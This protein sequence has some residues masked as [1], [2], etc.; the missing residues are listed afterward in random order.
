MSRL[1][2]LLKLA[3]A[4][5]NDEFVQYGVGLEY[6]QL[7]QWEPAL[8]YFDRAVEIKP[9]YIAGYYQ[10]SRA[11]LKLGRRDAARA[12]L[13][14]GIVAAKVQNQAHAASEMQKMLEAL[15]SAEP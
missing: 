12:T 4:E 5:P 10:K 6:M 3:A 7:E 14:R 13:T 9:D 15:E 8:R 1:E 2:K 11:E